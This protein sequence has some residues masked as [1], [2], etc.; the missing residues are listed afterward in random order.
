MY[1]IQGRYAKALVTIDNLE[2]NAVNQLYSLLNAASSYKSKVAIMP[3]G[4]TGKN[5]LVGFTQSFGDD[6]EIRLVPNYVG[7]DIS[8]GIFAW[9]LG[10]FTPNESTLGELDNFIKTNIGVRTPCK[11]LTPE[12]K[13][14]FHDEDERLLAEEEKFFGKG[15]S[16]TPLSSQ[17]CS[18]GGGNHFISLERSEKSGI[19]YLIVHTGSRYLGK[20]ICEL[21]QAKARL[22]HSE[23]CLSGLEY[24]VPGDGAFEGY[25]HFM[26]V[27]IHFSKRNKELIAQS[28]M[29]FLKI[30]EQ[31]GGIFTDHNYYSNKERIVRKGAVS[32]HKGELFLCPIN[33]RDGTLICVGKGNPDWNYSAP[34]GAGR[35]LSRSDARKDLDKELVEENL[36]YSGVFTTT[37]DTSEA[38]DAYKSA[39]FIKAHIEPTADIIDHLRPI[40]NFKG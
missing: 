4:H 29:N 31:D 13:K 34:H 32:A 9:P 6:V 2:E 26:D 11:Y 20:R 35:L 10:N 19:T 14:Y 23:R 25:T 16:R 33:M 5:C 28:V 36:K 30:E 21:Y 12:D 7:I 24:L 39:D 8:C 22:L 15:C 1:T 17:L 27:G 37:V 40:Y 18:L 38:P 3:D